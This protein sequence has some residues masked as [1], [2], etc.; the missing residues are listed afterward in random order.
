MLLSPL[1]AS[2]TQAWFTSAGEAVRAAIGG[3]GVVLQRPPSP[4]ESPFFS[5]DAPEVATGSAA[6][7]QAFTTDRIYFSDAI[8]DAWHQMRRARSFNVFSWDENMQMVADAGLRPDDSPIVKEVLEGQR[9]C[10]FTGMIGNLPDGEAMIWVLHRTRGGF[11]LGEHATALLRVLYP[12]F[13]TGLAH[14][15]QFD[16]RR[17]ALDALSDALAVFGI[18]GREVHRNPALETALASDPQRALVDACL[19]AT[20]R[21]MSRHAQGRHGGA[22]APALAT[23]QTP[24]GAYTL[25]ASLLPAGAFGPDASVLV[26]VEA[27]QVA[28]MPSSDTLRARLGLTKR[29]AEVALLLA[30]GH[31]NGQIAEALFVSPHTARHHVENVMGKLDVTARAAVAARLMAAA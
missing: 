12:A 4:G 15:A 24:L 16:A 29:E 13:Q 25:R 19:A 20:G 6:Y 18:D 5:L 1:A 2:D 22:A 23:V 17:A 27:P 10:D 3:T 9:F 28:T 14:L 7:L 26:T 8:V 21:T 11:P 30:E 31:T